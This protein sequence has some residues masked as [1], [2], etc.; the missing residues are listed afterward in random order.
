MG[1]APSNKKVSIHVIDI[2]RL[3]DGRYVEH[4]GMSNLA[5]IVKELSI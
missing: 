1:I 2:I 4:W 3:S 5:D